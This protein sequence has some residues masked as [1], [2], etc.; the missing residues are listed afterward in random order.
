MDRRTFIVLMVVLFAAII[1]VALLVRPG[2]G[3]PFFFL[4]I[5]LGLI[6]GGFTKTEKRPRHADGSHCPECG[7]AVSAGDEFC[8]VCGATLKRRGGIPG[9]RE[10]APAG[11]LCPISD[12]IC[13]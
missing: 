1:L 8:R 12:D 6:G 7:G 9:R 2:F 5:P 11:I 10:L 13:V 3:L 4:F